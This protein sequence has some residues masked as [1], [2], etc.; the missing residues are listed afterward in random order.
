M[1]TTARLGYKCQ[2][3]EGTVQLKT[4]AIKSFKH[5]A[6]FVIFQE[7]TVGVCAACGNRYYSAGVLHMVH[8]IATGRR[9]AERMAEV[10]MA[11]ISKGH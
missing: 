5:K 1:P 8:E 3:C 7:V 9:A 11:R 10:P 6:G 2:Y 4:V